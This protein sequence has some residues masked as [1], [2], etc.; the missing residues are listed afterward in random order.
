M[1]AIRRAGVKALVLPFEALA[2]IPRNTRSIGEF[3][4]APDEAEALA[5]AFDEALA[6]LPILP[7]RRT[8]YVLWWSP[9]VT[10]GPSSFIG[11]GLRRLG[12][13]PGPSARTGFPTVPVEELLAWAPSLVLYPADAGPPPEWLAARSGVRC[14]E[15]PADRW[16]RP[17]LDFPAALADLAHA[18]GD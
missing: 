11:E 1:A 9:P 16:N 13:E 4:G 12:L 10:A 6:A 15:V 8:A 5:R 14:I 18:L 3:L 2:D 17:A 7:A